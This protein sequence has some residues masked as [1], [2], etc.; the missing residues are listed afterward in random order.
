MN[1]M[2]KMRL[3]GL[4]ALVLMVSASSHATPVL[5]S[6]P[7]AAYTVYLDFDGFAFS[8][9]WGTGSTLTPGNTAAYTGNDAQKSDVWARISEKYSAFNIN[10]T[11]VD[12]AVAAQ[13]AG[14]SLAR[15][16]YYDATA[17]LMHTVIGGNGSWVG[18]GGIS[19]VGVTQNAQAGS[20]G[21]H[22]DFCFAAQA[23]N[24]TQFVAEASAHENGHGFSLN[25][26]GDSGVGVTNF[27]TEYSSNNGAVGNGS[28]APVMG[29]SYSTQR[30]TWRTG[31]Y[32][33]SLA[34]P[35]T[36]TNQN[37]ITNLLSNTG[38]SLVNDGIG[39]SFVTAT[40]LPLIGTTVDS[41]AAKGVI[42][43]SFV[44]A[45][46]PIGVGNYTKD[47]FKFTMSLNGTVSL[48]V[49]DG[50]DW[51]T[52]GTTAAGTTLRSKLNIYKSGDLIN[53]FAFASESADTL[54][55][56][57]T[58]LL[59]SGDYIAEVTS[60]GGYASTYDTSAKYY[61]MGSYVM[62]GSI[63]VVPEPGTYALLSLGLL[64]LLAK[65]RVKSQS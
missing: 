1:R 40:V 17:K 25:H 39:H 22:T 52:P 27:S 64:G 37:D 38:M 23:P 11:T 7:G 16:N 24:N 12:P 29:N 26:Q 2:Y 4:T 60:F 43:P 58:G 57:F 13:Q 14:T 34:K 9:N 19:Y 5:N 35:P 62:R 46:N 56:T 63:A 42:T 55:E 18:G 36:T 28:Y 30:G 32:Y 8:G 49:A 3:I 59:T 54:S 51:L 44:N 20:N 61:D 50:A 45:A 53:P 31:T 48:T 41:L 15:Q 65:R 6:R 10:V 33:N 47:Y 21:Y